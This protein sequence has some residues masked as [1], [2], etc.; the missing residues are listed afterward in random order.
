MA[1]AD[2]VGMSNPTPDTN[3]SGS[4][5][6]TPEG[7]SELDWKAS[8]ESLRQARDE[9]GLK[10]HLA[11][12]DAKSE[13]QKLEAKIHETHTFHS[14]TDARPDQEKHGVVQDLL[15]KVKAFREKLVK[16]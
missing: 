4:T 5:G 6:S 11:S 14:E 7:P 13:W 12:M 16:S 10:L 15:T 8:L 2:D 3:K 1:Y 9:I